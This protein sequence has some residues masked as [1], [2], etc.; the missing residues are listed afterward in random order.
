MS[1]IL[2]KTGIDHDTAFHSVDG[3]GREIA[4][5]CKFRPALSAEH[6]PMLEIGR[7]AAALAE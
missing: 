1:P 3:R 4:Y 6:H 7:Q 5:R 2:S